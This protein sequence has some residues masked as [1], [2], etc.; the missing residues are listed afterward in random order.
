MAAREVMAEVAGRLVGGMML[1]SD[2]ADLMAF[3]GL[4]GF[5]RYHER[6][7]HDDAMAFR[8]IHRATIK[9]TNMMVP[10]VD[11]EG[12]D[13]LSPYMN[14]DR[15]TLDSEAKRNALEGAMASW[16]EWE[17]GTVQTYSRAARDLQALG[18]AKLWKKVYELQCKAE[19][20]LAMLRKLTCDMKTCGWDMC[21]IL[22]MQEPLHE[23]YHDPC[24]GR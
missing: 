14:Y 5:K 15:M 9:Y 21:H 2:H 24:G 10:Q 17:Q 18:E 13:E 6:G 3:L 20:E 23:E 16:E 19:K 7:Y 11:Q 4:R 22:D 8:K 1:H 12:S